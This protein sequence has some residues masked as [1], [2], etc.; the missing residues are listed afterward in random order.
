MARTGAGLAALLTVAA[1]AAAAVAEET[2]KDSGM[3]NQVVTFTVRSRQL[4]QD[5]Q[6][7]NVWKV[8]TRTHTVKAAETALVLCD[9][10]D[11]HWCRGANERL[12]K[13]LPRM[14]QVVKTLRAK[15]VL[16]VHA[17]S[18]TMKFY[19]GNPARQ[20]V[21]DAPKV[22]PPNDIKHDDPRLPI[23]DSDGGSDTGEKPWHKAWSR[24]HPAIE[25]DEARDAV[26]D[27]GRDLYSLYR[28]RGIKNIVI[29]GVHTNMCV[30]GRS[31]AIKQ[32]VRWGFDVTLVRDL[33]DT[34]Y[35]PAR[36]PYVSHEEG[37]RL[38]VEYIE[39]FWCPTTTSDD[40]LKGAAKE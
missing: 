4:V 30:L 22:E 32:M 33:T 9:V 23:D 24:Q 13:L 6:G 1:L 18:G 40:L 5:D 17:P 21:L 20:R 28:Q 31:F 11:K 3:G 12:A 14:N 26:S 25:I 2:G 27:N 16:I 7:H 29:M 34:M 8:E 19:E 15:G 37:T 38:V 35:N 10:W 39:A 36:S